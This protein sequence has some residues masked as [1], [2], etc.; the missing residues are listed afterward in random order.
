M[1]MFALKNISIYFFSSGDPVVFADE[2]VYIYIFF[3]YLD[4]FLS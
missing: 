4:D 3:S 2:I 1:E